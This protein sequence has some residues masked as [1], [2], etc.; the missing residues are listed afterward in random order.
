LSSLTAATLSLSTTMPALFQPL[1]IGDITLQH[2]IAMAPLTRM[3]ATEEHVVQGPFSTFDVG[4]S[5]FVSLS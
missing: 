3:R 2:R 1:Q 5:S 4:G